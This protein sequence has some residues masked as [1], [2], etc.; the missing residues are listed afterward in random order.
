MSL[1]NND[2]QDVIKLVYGLKDH[3][4]E[5]ETRV[6]AGVNRRVTFNILETAPIPISKLGMNSK[7]TF[8]RRKF[9]K[10]GKMNDEE[11]GFVSSFYMVNDNTIKYA[12]IVSCF[13]EENKPISQ[14]TLREELEGFIE[15]VSSLF[16]LALDYAE[17][18]PVPS[19]LNF[20]Y[21]TER[22]PTISKNRV[23]QIK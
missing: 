17:V 20:H 2:A 9:V 12:L 16:K 19:I 14:V 8:V 18:E 13:V 10:E 5:K 4:F 22:K 1:S 7:N 23:R 3:S 6:V 15:V 21:A 11:N